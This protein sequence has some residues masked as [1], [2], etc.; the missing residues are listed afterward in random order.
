M[1]VFEIL[2]ALTISYATSLMIAQLCRQEDKANSVAFGRQGLI[3][4]IVQFAET[5][6]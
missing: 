5:V 6:S 3:R 2:H 1:L 4:R